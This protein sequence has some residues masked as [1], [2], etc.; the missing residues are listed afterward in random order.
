MTQP[1]QNTAYIQRIAKGMAVRY[2]TK[3]HAERVCRTYINSPLTTK[4][5]R[6]F[7]EYVLAEIQAMYTAE[8]T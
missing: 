2:G 7:W 1:H 4:E 6:I 3:A 8:G 5:G